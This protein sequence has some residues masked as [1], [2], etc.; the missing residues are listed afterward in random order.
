MIHGPALPQVADHQYL[1]AGDF[2]S[3]G[4]QKSKHDPDD[5]RFFRPVG[6]DQ[7]NHL[8]CPQGDVDVG[9]DLAVAEPDDLAARLDQRF[10]VFPRGASTCLTAFPVLAMRTEPLHLDSTVRDHEPGACSAVAD[11]RINSNVN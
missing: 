4:T 6:D 1:A 5:G 8:A 7:G 11:R 9:N 2:T 3:V 10:T